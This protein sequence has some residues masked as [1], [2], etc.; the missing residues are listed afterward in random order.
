MTYTCGSR[1]PGSAD[2]GSSRRELAREY[3]FTDVDG[4]RPDPFGILVDQPATA[5]HAGLVGSLRER[6]R[7]VAAVAELLGPFNLMYDRL[8]M[9]EQLGLIPAPA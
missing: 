5:R 6:E 7:E 8:L 2:G 9:L 1:R 3:G 4:S